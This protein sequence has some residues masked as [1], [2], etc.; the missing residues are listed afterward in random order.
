MISYPRYNFRMEEMQ[1]FRFKATRFAVLDREG[2]TGNPI[3]IAGFGK[4]VAPVVPPPGPSGS[5][6]GAMRDRGRIH[7]KLAAP[8]SD[9]AEWEV[10]GQLSLTS[11]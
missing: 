6:L 1:I 2:K 4:P 7:F 3:L 8:A 11:R 10:S 5:W 9:V